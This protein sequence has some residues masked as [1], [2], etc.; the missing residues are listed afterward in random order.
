MLEIISLG[1]GVINSSQ[2][3]IEFIKNFKNFVFKWLLENEKRKIILIV[4][5]GRV[6]REYQDAYKKINPDFKV[7]ELDEIGIMSTK[8]N[9]E[10]LCK[11][12]N[13]LCK[14]KIVTNPLKNFSFKGKILIASGW[15]SGF[16][17]DYI[18][19]K[20]AE[21]FNKKD[22][23]NITNVN[24]VYDKDPKKFKNATAFKKLNW[25]QLQNIVGQK[26]NPGLNLPFD[27]IATKLSSK[28]GLTLYIVN[29]N[30]IENLEK[31]FNKNNDFFGT[32]IVK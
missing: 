18:A 7:H 11:V 1:G 4:G 24:Q 9:A 13:P 8:L 23:I 6:A 2:I 12:M 22:I 10:F 16:S 5:G 26:W 15:K 29:G 19:V 20:F 32:V 28:L 30:N 21:K 31:V 27:P 25:E 17:T 14:D 3:N